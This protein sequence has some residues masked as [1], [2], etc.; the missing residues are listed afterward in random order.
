MDTSAAGRR[1]DSCLQQQ[2]QQRAFFAMEW[3]FAAVACAF[4][5]FL[6]LL[7]LRRLESRI[8]SLQAAVKELERESMPAAQEGEQPS[9]AST[10]QEMPETS[11]DAR[12]SAFLNIHHENMRTPSFRLGAGADDRAGQLSPHET[13]AATVER[14]SSG[15]SRTPSTAAARERVP[16]DEG[17]LGRRGAV[18]P[19]DA[20]AKGIERESS[21][22][23]RTS[24]ADRRRAAGREEGAR[25]VPSDEGVGSGVGGRRGD[26]DVRGGEQSSEAISLR[27]RNIVREIQHLCDG[28]RGGRATQ[29]GRAEA[30]QGESPSGGVRESLAKLKLLADGEQVKAF[31]RTLS[32]TARAD[33][34]S[35]LGGGAGEWSVP[36]ASRHAEET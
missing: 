15:I 34:L 12:L 11:P 8:H 2:Q 35:S 18:V 1:A 36:P 32:S 14:E 23:S 20:R 3:H 9:D 5:C 21:G 25:R 7:L 24:S 33:V 27:S 19:Y 26:A 28:V 30:H 16:S 31:L 17:V 4:G 22:I 6:L 10:P 29:E 13:S